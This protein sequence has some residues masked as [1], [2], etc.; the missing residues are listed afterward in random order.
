M[1]EAT[2]L[3]NPVKKQI[4]IAL[5]NCG[6]INP[7]TIDEY[8][9]KDGYFAL[10]KVLTGLTPAEAIKVRLA[11]TDVTGTAACT[12]LDAYLIQIIDE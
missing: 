3:A 4:R 10:G 6:V 12:N 5:R 2:L 1:P 9:G 8:I 7:E 11:N